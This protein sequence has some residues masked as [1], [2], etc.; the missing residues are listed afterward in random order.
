[1]K[2]SGTYCWKKIKRGEYPA[3]E[4]F[5]IDRESECVAACSRFMHFKANK[6]HVWALKDETGRIKALL[7]HHRRSLFPILNSGTDGKANSKAAGKAAIPLP[8]F[9]NSFLGKVP[10]HA[11]Q[12]LLE[13]TD[14][15]TKAMENLGYFAAE[16]LD[17]DLMALDT[18]PISSCY[19]Y[20][21]PGLLLR[22][23]IPADTDELFHL[24]AAYEREEVLPGGAEFNPAACRANLEHLLKQE[25][26]LVA[27]LGN[28]IVGKIN[29]SAS[30]YTRRQIGGVYV[31]PDCRSMGIAIRMTAVFLKGI[32]DEGRG[33]TLFVKKRNTIARSVYK[34][35]GLTAQ[36]NYRISY[37]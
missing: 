13:D 26:M 10:I 9:L 18:Q 22:P 2:M 11:V 1:M 6:G 34:R 3:A 36:G 35:V 21:P 20:G 15:L 32:I 29:T 7:L 24:Q 27:C 25:Q 12:G 4:E 23:P 37:F 8:R 14:I 5:L 28:R 17:Y 33:V 16:H 30:S 19:R 31:H